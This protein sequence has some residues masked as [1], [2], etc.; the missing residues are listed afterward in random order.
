MV[1]PSARKGRSLT[2][3]ES[4]APSRGR[5][6]MTFR[7]TDFR[8]YHGFRRRAPRVWGLECATTMTVR[9][10]CRKVPAVHSLHLPDLW[11]HPDWLGIASGFPRG[12][13][14]FDGIQQSVSAA[15][16]QLSFK[17][18]ASTNFAIGASQ[19]VYLR[20]ASPRREMKARLRTLGSRILSL[21]ERS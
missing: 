18:V 21:P 14:D 9:K 8:T 19:R 6:G 17:S 7:S 1:C 16:A 13:A 10:I 11:L 20:I 12:F 5:T 2:Q 3:S 4:G 15:A